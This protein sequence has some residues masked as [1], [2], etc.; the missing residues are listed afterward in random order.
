MAAQVCPGQ[1][2]YYCPCAALMKP[3]Q[4]VLALFRGLATLIHSLADG[5]LLAPHRGQEHQ[6]Q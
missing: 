1:V 5:N 6:G 2:L 4:Y 3:F